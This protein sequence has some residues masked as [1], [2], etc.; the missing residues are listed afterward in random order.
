MSKTLLLR[1]SGLMQSWGTDSYNS[2]RRTNLEPSKSGIVGLLAACLGIERNDINN[3]KKLNELEFGVRVDQRGTIMR[4]FQ[5]AQY[6]SGSFVILS[7]MIKKAVIEDGVCTDISWDNY[8]KIRND[9]KTQKKN[10]GNIQ[11]VTL[12]KYY[13]TD[14]IFTVALS[15]DDISFLDEIVDAIKSP[16]YTPYL[17]RKNCPVNI[18]MLIGIV[19]KD[20]DEALRTEGFHI[21]HQY[22]TFKIIRDAKPGEGYKLAK[23]VPVS[24]DKNDR[25]Y[26]YRKVYKTLFTRS[27]SKEEDKTQKTDQDLKKHKKKEKKEHD[28]MALFD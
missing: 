8:E 26:T 3:I 24:F 19:D 2:Y 15:S 25:K 10:L 12:E 1:I 22:G 23:D 7:N 14:A 5:V 27:E 13:L 17:G 21:N 18:D 9:P 11:T 16:T 28:T 6:N 4:D 20:L